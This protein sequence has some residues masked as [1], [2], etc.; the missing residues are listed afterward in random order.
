MQTEVD[1]KQNE[2]NKML[3]I[4]D[5]QA[6]KFLE[7]F[8][9]TKNIISVTELYATKFE[10]AFVEFYL[11]TEKYKYTHTE[12][13]WQGHMDYIGIALFQ[14]QSIFEEVQIRTGYKFKKLNF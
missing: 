4:L 6:Q 11:L 12:V 7:S 8:N 10:D 14:Y 13:M 5:Q 2:L 1:Y 3:A 9:I